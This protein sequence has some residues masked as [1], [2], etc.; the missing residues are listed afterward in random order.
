MFVDEIT[1]KARA[2]RGGAGVVR[3]R[4]EKGKEFSGAAGGNG[5]RGGNIYARAVRDISILGKYRG[6]KEFVSGHGGAGENNSRHGKNGDDLYIDFPVGSVITNQKTGW[7]YELMEEGQTERLLEGGRGGLGNEHFKASTNVTPFE[8]T[9]GL[10]GDSTAFHIELK[11][12]VDAGLIGLPNAGKS[13]LL[14]ALTRATAKIGSYAFTTLE[15][16]LGDFYGYILADVP[17][18]IEGAAEGKG[19]GHKFL[20]HISRTKMLLHCISLENT[21]LIATYKTIR[22]ELEKFDPELLEKT[23][24]IILTKTDLLTPDKVKK[25]VTALKKYNKNVIAVSIYDFDGLKTLGDYLTKFFKKE[26]ARLKKKK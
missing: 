20:K 5:G 21:A 23:E 7:T 24:I 13:S 18:L 12:I 22:E 25:A 2:G 14:N 15:P 26:E 19:L 16:N 8:H 6:V 3:W 17:G 10:E 1:I 11:L 9:P 4:H